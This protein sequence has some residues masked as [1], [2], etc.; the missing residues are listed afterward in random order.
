[1]CEEKEPFTSN[2]PRMVKWDATLASLTEKPRPFLRNR[3]PPMNKWMRMRLKWL[4]VDNK[5]PSRAKS[6]HGRQNPCIFK[7]SR[8]ETEVKSQKA[9]SCLEIY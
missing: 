6:A 1:M 8:D 5:D 2:T 3:E 7:P 9:G 4:D